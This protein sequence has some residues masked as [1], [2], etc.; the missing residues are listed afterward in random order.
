MEMLY[1]LLFGINFLKPAF[2]DYALTINNLYLFLFI[3]SILIIGLFF[4]SQGF[5]L[6]KQS[7][8]PIK[9]IISFAILFNATLLFVWPMGSSDLFT[10]IY[11]SRIISVYHANPYITSYDNFL[12]DEFYDPLNNLW[13]K[14]TNI[15]GPIFTLSGAAL[16]AIGKNNLIFNIFLFKFFFIIINIGVIFLIQKITKNY[17][18]TFLYAWNPFILYEFAVN[19]HNDILLIF[20]I[21]LSLLFFLKNNSFAT[22]LY[23]WFWLICSVLIKFFSLLFLPIYLIVIIKKLKNKKQKLKFFL[24]AAV[25]SI[26]TIGFFYWPFWE[27]TAIFNR[28]TALISKDSAFASIGILFL[29]TLLS[30]IHAP[31]AYGLSKIINKISF[32]V[33]YIMLLVRL[34]FKK[35]INKNTDLLYYMIISLSLF[36]AMFFTWFMPWYLSTLLALLIVYIGLA[37]KYNLDIIIY[38]ISIYGISFYLLLR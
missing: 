14:N 25:I 21:L 4:Y 36:M 10:Y 15:Y 12:Q 27:G 20:F 2:N 32:G 7:V 1:L 28:L 11:R 17:K 31:Y 18:A 8:I 13:S 22:Y 30:F 34:I 26:A 29:A 24:L 6:I 23:S 33:L 3:I 16:T 35:T 38:A 5:N 37:K 9:I 19:G